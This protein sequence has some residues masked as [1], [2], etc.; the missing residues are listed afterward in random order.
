MTGVLTIYSLK[1][2]DT[3]LSVHITPPFW[4]NKFREG[5]NYIIAKNTESFLHDMFISLSIPGVECRKNTYCNSQN[6]VI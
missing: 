1:V 2:N 5:E 4:T 6:D 3:A